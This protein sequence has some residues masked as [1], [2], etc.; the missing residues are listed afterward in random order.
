MLA[1]IVC[2]NKRHCRYNEKKVKTVMDNNATN[3]DKRVV[4]PDP[5]QYLDLK[6]WMS[7]PSLWSLILRSEV[8]VC[9]FDIDGIVDHHGLN[10]HFIITSHIESLNIKRNID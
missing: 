1:S 4:V 10:L 9:F 7:C 5:S 3:I 8:I 2:L 6:R